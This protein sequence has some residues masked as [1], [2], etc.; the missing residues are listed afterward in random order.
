MQA[1]RLAG[2]L[3]H[4]FSLKNRRI[5]KQ[6]DRHALTKNLA[7]LERKQ[8]PATASRTASQ[9]TGH[10]EID[11]LALIL[12][13]AHLGLDVVQDGAQFPKLVPC[14]EVCG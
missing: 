13:I 12:T 2:I 14:G 8:L 11:A 7:C 10:I 1:I 9:A 4:D 3:L 6:T 5:S